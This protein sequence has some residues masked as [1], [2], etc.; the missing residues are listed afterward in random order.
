LADAS[1]I[2]DPNRTTSRASFRSL[3]S[4]RQRSTP[5]WKSSRSAATANGLL[6]PWNAAAISVTL[7]S[8]SR[9]SAICRRRN[10]SSSLN[11][12]TGVPVR[13]ATCPIRSSAASTRGRSGT[14]CD[15]IAS[16]NCLARMMTDCADSFAAC[17]S[18]FIAVAKSARMTS[19][20]TSANRIAAK[21][22]SL[23]P[24]RLYAA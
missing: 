7:T 12:S 9:A 18:P 5:R 15:R 14:R 20:A 3:S 10:A 1:M 22:R 16:A 11:A 23:A 4:T 13:E 17:S 2:R 21:S 19:S 8:S 6:E 24:A